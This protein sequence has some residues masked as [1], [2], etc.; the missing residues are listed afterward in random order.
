MRIQSRRLN[1]KDRK[2]QILKIAADIS[3][4]HGYEKASLREIG[5]RAGITKAAIY[6][7]FK[8]KEEVLLNLV[9]TISDQLISD[10]KGI[11]RKRS[12]KGTDGDDSC[13]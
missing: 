8:N 12:G 11:K 1:T 9:T 2:D 4:R 3:Y 5:E 6:Y 13:P 7:H 10:L